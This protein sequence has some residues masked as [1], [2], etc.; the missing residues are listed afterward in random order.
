[1]DSFEFEVTDGYNPVFRTFRISLSDVDNKKPVLMLEPLQAREGAVKLITPFELKAVD[2]DTK[3]DKIVFN[4]VR[5][6]IHGVLLKNET[7]PVRQFTMEDLNENLITY[8]HD[9]S[10]STMDSIRLTVTDGTHS[11]FFVFPHTTHTTTRPQTLP[12]YILSVDDSLPQVAINTGAT[13]LQP[14]DGNQLG[15]V[16]TKHNLKAEDSDTPD[17]QLRYSVI[18]PPLCGY[19]VNTANGQ[20]NITSWTQ[21][22]YITF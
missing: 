18:N 10:E 4:V 5:K 3:D 13:W 2:S 7:E 16:F 21:G 9:D 8:K 1:M 17:D 22:N 20:K 14:V 11:D 15:H 12:I 6:P 19:L